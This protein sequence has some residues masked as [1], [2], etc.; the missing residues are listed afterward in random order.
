MTVLAATV[1]AAGLWL[2]PAPA[3]PDGALDEHLAAMKVELT[4]RRPYRF[5]LRYSGPTTP[6]RGLVCYH[7]AGYNET[8]LDPRIDWL[9]PATRIELH[10]PGGVPRDLLE[11]YML[12][13]RFP[14]LSERTFRY[15]PTRRPAE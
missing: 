7:F 1:A 6:F 8:C 5:L 10:A 4:D 11:G 13:V 14:A 9:T 3:L 12:L 15:P 2:A